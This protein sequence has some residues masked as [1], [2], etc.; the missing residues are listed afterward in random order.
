MKIHGV[1]FSEIPSSNF[2]IKSQ[3]LYQ[4]GVVMITDNAPCHS[5]IEEIFQENEFDIHRLLILGRYSLMLNS[6]EYT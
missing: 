4:S 6:I 2:I 3:V 1:R 5:S